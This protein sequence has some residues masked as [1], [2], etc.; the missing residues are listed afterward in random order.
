MKTLRIEKALRLYGADLSEEYTPLHAG[1]GR[2]IVFNRRD[3]IGREALLR[4]Q[5]YGLRQR[6]VGLSLQSEMAAATGDKG[7]SIGDVAALRGERVSGSEAGEDR[8]SLLPGEP[9][10]GH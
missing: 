4:V 10:V 9:E 5:E 6:W 3:F 2:W 7:Y 1:L 8:G